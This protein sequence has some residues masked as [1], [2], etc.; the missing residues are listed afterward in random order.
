MLKPTKFTL[1]AIVLLAIYLGAPRSA[2]ADQ[3][4]ILQSPP[5]STF[6]TGTPG[7]TVHIATSATSVVNQAFTVDDR[8]IVSRGIGVLLVFQNYLLTPAPLPISGEAYSTV[9]CEVFDFNITSNAAAGFYTG[10]LHITG[11]LADGT[12]FTDA[13]PIVLTITV[14]TEVPEPAT[15]L[16]LGTGLTGVATVYRK[17]RRQS[18]AL[19]GARRLL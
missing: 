16:L 4:V 18:C 12:A 9:P 15:M 13:L 7:G 3:F 8:M 6:L 5:G 14:P 2:Q 1:V 17:R 10:D 11:H 19:K